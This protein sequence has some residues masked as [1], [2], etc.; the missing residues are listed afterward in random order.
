[1]ALAYYQLNKGKSMLQS[2]SAREFMSETTHTVKP[3]SNIMDAITL[4]I[5]HKISGLS[6]I[7]DNNNLLGVISEVDCLRA[8]LDG[9]Y[10]GEVGGNVSDYMTANVQ[11]VSMDM[12]II[13]IA[14]LILDNNRRRMP[15]VE[16][17][18]LQGQFSIRSILNAIVNMEGRNKK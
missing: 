12:T 5:E 1:V 10:Y 18:K 4:L 3:D 9:S 17:G 16:N 2:I 14:K 11:S 6:V 15:V 7:D 8:I 13:D